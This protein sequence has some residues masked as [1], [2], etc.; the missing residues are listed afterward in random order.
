MKFHLNHTPPKADFE[1]THSDNVLLLGSC[2][3]ENIGEILENH[4]FNANTNPPGILFNPLSIS[5]YLNNC[6]QENEISHNYIIER[7]GEYFCYLNHSSVNAPSKEKLEVKIK[8]IND[9]TLKQLKESDFLIITFGTA[10]YYNHKNMDVCVANCHK[11]NSNIF[12]KKLLSIKEI[13]DTYS[14]LISELSKLNPKLKIIFTVSPVKYLKDGLV[15]N[16][17]SKSTLLLSVNE[18]VETN[19]NCFYFPA[20]ELVN[21]DLRDYRF[22]KE[23]MAHPN[24]KAIRYVWDKFS[25]TYFS[26]KTKLLVEK[27]AELN[28]AQNHRSLHNNSEE[29]LKFQQHIMGLEQS[30]KLIDPTISF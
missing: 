25:G 18:L 20:Y 14:H 6:L 13:T 5:N 19:K 24:E 11:Q 23:D 7:G 3:A 21:D 22:Y 27:I 26:N 2:F 17:I 12:E 30:I 8:S 4:K 10:F 1:I 16:N 9:S 28:N 29:K 15:E